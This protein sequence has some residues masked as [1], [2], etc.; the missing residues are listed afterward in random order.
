MVN[1][2][3]VKQAPASPIHSGQSNRQ[4]TGH[5]CGHQPTICASHRSNP[6]NFP[7]A[8]PAGN[9]HPALPL[10]RK[11]VPLIVHVHAKRLLVVGIARAWVGVT[12]LVLT[13]V[14]VVSSPITQRLWTWDRYLNGGSDFETGVLVILISLSLVLLIAQH[15]KQTMKALATALQG[16]SPLANDLTAALGELGRIAARCHDTG[17]PRSTHRNFNLPLTI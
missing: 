16:S 17:G 5:D 8:N 15:C 3:A 9:N 12:L 6:L 14:S 10:Q 7:G 1:V 2:H 4:R 13:A 11:R